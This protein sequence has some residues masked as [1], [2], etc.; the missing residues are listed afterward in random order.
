[1]LSPFLFCEET[2]LDFGALRLDSFAEAVLLAEMADRKQ[3]G[4][5]REFCMGDTLAVEARAALIWS[6]R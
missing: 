4:P 5:C 1:M 3:E 2:T 6:R